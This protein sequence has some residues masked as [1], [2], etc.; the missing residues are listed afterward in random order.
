MEACAVWFVVYNCRHCGRGQHTSCAKSH[1]SNAIACSSLKRIARRASEHLHSDGK[2]SN[3]IWEC[4]CGEGLFAAAIRSWWTSKIMG[5]EYS[6]TLQ[7]FEIACLVVCLYFWRGWIP[8]NLTLLYY[9]HI[10]CQWES[11]KHKMTS[12]HQT[13]KAGAT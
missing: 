1:H 2:S 9:I 4:T 12:Q 13:S 7:R 8:S 6:I 11:W 5:N 10:R 3:E